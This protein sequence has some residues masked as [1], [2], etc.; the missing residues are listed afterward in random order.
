MIY[1]I[2]LLS[3]YV[4][5]YIYIYYIAKA[6]SNLTAPLLASNFHWITEVDMIKE[7]KHYRPWDRVIDDLETL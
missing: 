5:L 2:L 7:F 4:Y 3:L 1:L 6:D